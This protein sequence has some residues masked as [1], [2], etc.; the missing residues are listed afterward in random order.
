M[1]EEAPAPAPVVKEEPPAPA[2][3][4]PEPQAVFTFKDPNSGAVTDITLKNSPL[5][6][7]YKTNAVPV[8]IVAFPEKSNAKDA[9]V[10]EGFQLVKVNGVDH[11]S[12]SWATVDQAIKDAAGALPKN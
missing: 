11:S 3:P 2:P 12:S 8:V 5:G 1:G 10:K 9:G 6:M 7:R 4:P